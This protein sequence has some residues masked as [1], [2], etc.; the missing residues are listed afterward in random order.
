MKCRVEIT[1]PALKHLGAIKDLQVRK[2]LLARIEQLE[3][4]P[5]QQGKPLKDDLS[6][7]R[8]VRAVN[9]RYRI[10]YQVSDEQITV[11]VIAVGI[12]WQGDRSDIY[13]IAAQLM[14]TRFTQDL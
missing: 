9:Q 10:I 7:L 13:R 14:Q 12:R 1:K 2:K 11:L 5:E 8:S 4:D 3:N 6:G